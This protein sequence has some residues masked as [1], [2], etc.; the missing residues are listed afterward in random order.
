MAYDE[1]QHHRRSI[2]LKDYDYA[3]PGAYFVTL[4]T[5][6]HL[7]L[8]GSVAEDEMRPNESGRMVQAVWNE[9]PEHYPGVAIDVFALMP[10]HIH[11]IIV[12]TSSVGA[13][14][15][16][17]PDPRD[18]DE[19][20]QQTEAG[21]ARGPAP[22]KVDDERCPLTLGAVVARFKTLTT[23]RYSAGVKLSHWLPFR[24]RLWQRNYYEHIIRCERALNHI[25]RYIVE[26]PLRWAHDRE[27]PEASAL[28]M[29]DAWHLL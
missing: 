19:R 1:K 21:Q 8:F 17:C 11:G 13:T 18:H 28:E 20:Q 6:D 4:C 2:R 5:Q 29:P 27:N 16:G 23:R 25:R 10:N 26:N 12:L 7:C 15:R 9:L 24:G 3:E 14:P 22:T